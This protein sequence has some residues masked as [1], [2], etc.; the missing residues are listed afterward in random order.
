MAPD[1]GEEASSS[2]VILKHLK[3]RHGEAR[4]IALTFDRKHQRFTPAEPTESGK[5]GRKADNGKLQSALR[6]L[7]EGTRP[8]Q[9]SED[10]G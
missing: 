1:D 3:S 5:P 2:R 10:E 4:D 6:A 9:D 8:A 7:W